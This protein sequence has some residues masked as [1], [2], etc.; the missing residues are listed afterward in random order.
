MLTEILKKDASVIIAEIH[1]DFNS[2]EERLLLKAERVVANPHTEITL[3]A[4]RVNKLGFGA[5]KPATVGQSVVDN[6]QSSKEYIDNR[7]YFNSK[8][9]LY[10]FITE[11]EVK[12]LC[13]KWYLVLGDADK[14]I[15]DIPEKNIEEIEKFNLKEEDFIEVAS[16]NGI[17]EMMRMSELLSWGTTSPFAEIKKPEAKTELK[18][19]KPAFKICAPIKDFNLSNTSVK[20]GYKLE[21]NIPDPI[22][23]Q[24]VKGGY[25]IVSKWG[26][27]ASDEIVVNEVFN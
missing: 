26:N 7:K 22:V 23:L 13:E 16:F 8:Y 17:W 4:E 10:K 1:N 24:P 3:K 5:S 2:A 18:K 19:E 20:D 14:Y 9:P 15:G 12:R 27:E 21:V 25:L 6:Y 11:S